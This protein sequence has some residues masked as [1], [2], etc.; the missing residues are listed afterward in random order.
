MEFTY[1]ITPSEGGFMATC[2]ELAVED[3]GATPAA[4]LE[5]LREALAERMVTVEAIAPPT[6]TTPVK[7]VLSLSPVQPSEPQGPGDSPAAAR[8]SSPRRG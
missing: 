7:V 5:A 3:S 2:Q 8:V 1:R 4:A 6:T